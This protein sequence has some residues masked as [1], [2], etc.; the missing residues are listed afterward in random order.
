MQ[1][2][3]VIVALDFPSGKEAIR[4]LDPFRNPIFVKIG[5]ELFYAEGPDI[6]RAVRDLGHEVFLDLKFH[7]IPNTVSGAVRSCANLDVAILNVHAAGGLDMMRAAGEALQVCTGRRPRLIAIT[8]LTSTSQ[9][10]MNEELQIPGTV[11]DSVLHL[12]KQVE[13]AGLDGVVCSAQ[14]VQMIRKQL[15]NDFLTVTPGI[16]PRSGEV[17]DQK[18][19][20]TPADAH[21]LGSDYIVVGRPITRAADPLAAYL[22]IAKEFETGLEATL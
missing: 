7:D 1:A 22:Q 10:M 9:Q 4:F 6:V 5:M 16:R 21:H 12:A 14:E 8:Q 15:G 2:N 20:V 3:R 18:R 11:Q 17:G 13:E 19:V